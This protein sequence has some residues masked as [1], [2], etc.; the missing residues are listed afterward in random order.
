MEFFPPVKYYKLK[1]DLKPAL[2]QKPEARSSNRTE[3]LLLAPR[4]LLLAAVF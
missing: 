3:V 2:R 4:F 1:L